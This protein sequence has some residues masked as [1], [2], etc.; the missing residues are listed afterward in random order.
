MNPV[1]ETTDKNNFFSKNDLSDQRLGDFVRAS[2]DS[3]NDISAD[4]VIWGYP[5]DEG[6][7]LN[8]GRPGACEAPEIIRKFFYKMTPHTDVMTMPR[9]IDFG[10][11]SKKISLSERH[12]HGSH[13]AKAFTE[14]KQSWLSL[15]GG[16]DYGYAD[17]AGFLRAANHTEKPVVVNFDAH[18]DVRPTTNGY[19]SGTPF[20]RLLTEFPGEFDFFE[21]GIQAQCNSQHHLN[22][23][24]SKGAQVISLPE[25]EKLGLLNS[26][27]NKMSHLQGRPLWFSLD[28]DALTSNEAPG[29]SQSWT[30]GL[31]ATDV[32]NTMSWFKKYFQWRSF[33]IYEVSPSL[34]QDNRTSKLAA[35]FAHH[36][37]ALQMASDHEY[38]F[39]YGET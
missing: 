30:T 32:L 27:K 9:L 29:C 21:V 28:I 13:I 36:Y 31:K 39:L 33:S 15:G 37:L 1:W 7:T 8:G 17:G 23:A 34:D 2:H 16:H 19:N 18:L 6:I 25:I 10:N 26:L 12:Q 35:L 4:L 14:K 5:D 20:F 24:K 22:W 38:N 3:P 11:I